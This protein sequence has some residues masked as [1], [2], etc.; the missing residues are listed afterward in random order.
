QKLLALAHALIVAGRHEMIVDPF[1]LARAARPGGH[2]DGQV[3]AGIVGEKQP[4][5]GRLSRPGRRGDDEHETT[6]HGTGGKRIDHSIFCTCSRNCSTAAFNFK[7]VAV[8]LTSFDFEHSVLASRLNS[9]AR[10]SS[11]RPTASP[12]CIK[13]RAAAIWARSRSS[14]S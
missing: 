1:H 10:K 8:K 2:R 12:A 3:D 5:Q 7:P 11:L 9:C 13:S 14:S 6:T 4:R